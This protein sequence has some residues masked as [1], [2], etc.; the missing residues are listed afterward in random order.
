MD[1]VLPIQ[2]SKGGV[3][4]LR[5]M[6]R[7][8]GAFTEYSARWFVLGGRAHCMVYLLGPNLFQPDN[9]P[10]KHK[11]SYRF[12]YGVPQAHMACYSVFLDRSVKHNL[13]GEWPETHMSRVEETGAVV[14]SVPLRKRRIV[15]R[16]VQMFPAGSPFQGT[17]LTVHPKKVSPPLV[18]RRKLGD[19]D[20]RHSRSLCGVTQICGL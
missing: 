17:G 14:S 10:A 18:P 5:A 4:G 2:T 8:K 11:G 20:R 6:G 1:F 13:V 16:S 7:V 9:D 15:E 3:F 12:H 19:R